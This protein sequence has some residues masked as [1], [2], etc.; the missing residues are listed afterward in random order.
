MLHPVMHMRFVS[1]LKC[2]ICVSYIYRYAYTDLSEPKY[3]A[4]V[5][6]VEETYSEENMVTFQLKSNQYLERDVI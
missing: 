6:C 2:N 1:I 4:F 5:D 3:E